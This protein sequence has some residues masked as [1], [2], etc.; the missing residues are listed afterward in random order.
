MPAAPLTFLSRHTHGQP[1]APRLSPPGSGH[2]LERWQ[3]TSATSAAP[4][5]LVVLRKHF[6]PVP[7]SPALAPESILWVSK[8]GRHGAGDAR[9]RSAGLSPTC[10]LRQGRAGAW[11]EPRSCG[12]AGPGPVRRPAQ[13]RRLREGGSPGRAGPTRRLPGRFSRRAGLAGSWRCESSQQFGGESA[14]RSL[15]HASFLEMPHPSGRV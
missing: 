1:G 14:G 4:S 15:T 5:V 3:G 12:P 10:A 11:A 9:A 6:L 8:A 2:P 13:S 7:C